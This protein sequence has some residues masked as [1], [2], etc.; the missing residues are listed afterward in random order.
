MLKV[1]RQITLIL[2]YCAIIDEFMFF[3]YSALGH[4]AISY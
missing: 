3:L 1:A 2:R 4:I